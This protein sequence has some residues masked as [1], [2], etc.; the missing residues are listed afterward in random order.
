MYNEELYH[1][2]VKGMKWGHRKAQRLENRAVRKYKR[3]GRQAG[4]AAY[5]RDRGAEALR[6]HEANA[7]LLDRQ[8]KKLDANGNIFGAEAAR[9]SA[10]A[11]RARGANVK[12]QHDETASYHEARSARINE[13]ANKYATKKRVD[14]GK[15]R[16]DSILAESKRQG[17]E[18]AK[19]NEQFEREQKAREWLGNTGYDV[20]SKARGK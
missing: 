5:E 20:Y 7:Q 4:M 19:E 3:A 18:L 6:K 14:L 12:A 17:Y 1:Y 10:A 2:G 11:I 16:V 8:A 13:R 15:K 9:R